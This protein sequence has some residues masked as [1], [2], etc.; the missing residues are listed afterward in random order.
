MDTDFV[1]ANSLCF[2]VSFWHI[3]SFL[4]C[5]KTYVLGE[6]AY[7][8]RAEVE[9]LKEWF[10]YSRYKEE[11]PLILRV[12]YFA[13]LIV[14]LAGLIASILIKKESPFSALTLYFVAGFDSM[15]MFILTIFF[16][17]RG[18]GFVFERW[19]RKNRG[20]KRNKK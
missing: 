11:I 14:N 2:L 9:T 7:E 13:I 15:Y 17:K 18:H 20:K 8:E 16:W 19:I 10:F 3:R 12:L 6:K 5:V 1:I 4:S